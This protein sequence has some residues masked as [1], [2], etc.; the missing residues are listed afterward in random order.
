MKVVTDFMEEGKV[1]PSGL[2]FFPTDE[3]LICGKS[4][5][6]DVITEL[7]LYKFD[8]EELSKVLHKAEN[9]WTVHE[10]TM[11]ENELKMCDTIE[12]YAYISSSFDTRPLPEWK[13]ESV[14]LL[15]DDEYGVT[16]D[17]NDPLVGFE[18]SEDDVGQ[19]GPDGYE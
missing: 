14:S 9:E 17:E 13:D 5:V 19:V 10:Y 11:D 4:L 8:P 7:D 1:L 12:Y 6:V 16:D 15:V 18:L 2:R 3:E